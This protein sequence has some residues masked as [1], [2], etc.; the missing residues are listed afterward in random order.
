MLQDMPKPG[1][2][3]HHLRPYIRNTKTQEEMPPRYMTDIESQIILSMIPVQTKQGYAY[4]HCLCCEYHCYPLCQTWSRVSC[5]EFWWWLLEVGL[6]C[7][8]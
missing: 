5:N 4:E 2:T 3:Q 7:G 8:E 1:L 6:A